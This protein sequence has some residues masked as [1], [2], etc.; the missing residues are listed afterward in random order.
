MITC[1]PKPVFI[2]TIF[3]L[4]GLCWGIWLYQIFHF[5]LQEGFWGQLT[6][7]AV[8]LLLAVL[9]LTIAVRKYF[10]LQVSAKGI[11]LVYAL[12][13]K[14]VIQMARTDLKQWREIRT[15]VGQRYRQLQLNF[16]SR[17]ISIA[18]LEHTDYEKLLAWLQKNA[19]DKRRAATI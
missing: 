7:I 1:R 2:N 10:T 5:R 13:H 11:E 4:S 9:L 6:G 14:R 3:A 15:G 19:A 12:P 18:N 8:V 16:G 17:Q